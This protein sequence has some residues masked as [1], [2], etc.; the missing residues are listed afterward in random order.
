MENKDY[1]KTKRTFE[2]V[3][4]TNKN[5]IKGKEYDMYMNDAS[6]IGIFDETGRFIPQGKLPENGILGIINFGRGK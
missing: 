4:T 1:Y 2:V 6:I 3:A 5:V